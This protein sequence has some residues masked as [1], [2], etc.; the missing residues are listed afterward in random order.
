MPANNAQVGGSHY[1]ATKATGA[2]PKCGSQIQHWD[3]Y[4]EQPYLVGQITKYVTREKGGLQ[5][6]EKAAHF[7]Q[8][9][10]EVRY[11]GVRVSIHVDDQR[12]EGNSLS[13]Q[14]SGFQAQE[15]GAVYEGPQATKTLR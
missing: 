8:K 4:A 2:C 12:P 11:P 5:D 14:Q 15:G 3:L 6:Y 9:L 1:M 10:I 7:L 13:G